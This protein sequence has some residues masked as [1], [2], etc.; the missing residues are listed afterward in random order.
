MM[1][2]S[3]LPKLLLLLLTLPFCGCASLGGGALPAGLTDALGSITGLGGN[4]A[5]WQS[6]LGEML[7]GTALGQ[8]K[9]YADQAGN[10]GSTISGLKDGLSDAMANPLAAIGDKLAGMSGIDIDGLK[11]LAP[12]AQMDSV[13]EFA[14]SAVG[15]GDLATE[16]LG[17]FGK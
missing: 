8:L 9:G 6:G 13:R 12:E 15:V 5:Q 10:L 17:K 2:L 1:N 7:D 16:F 4:I 3:W 11:Q 14:G